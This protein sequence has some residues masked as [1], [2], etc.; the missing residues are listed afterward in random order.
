MSRLFAAAFLVWWL[1]GPAA[2]AGLDAAAIN[3]AEY[4]QRSRSDGSIDPPIISTVR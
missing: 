3:G 1:A 4:R 2:A